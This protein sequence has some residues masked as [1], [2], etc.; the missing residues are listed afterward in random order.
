MKPCH[1]DEKRA[2]EILHALCHAEAAH[3]SHV[4]DQVLGSDVSK[5]GR[6]V[7]EIIIGQ[8]AARE[9]PATEE[10]QQMREQTP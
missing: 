2:D 3:N 8:S 7:V 10:L 5:T 6:D 9:K 1:Q 4:L